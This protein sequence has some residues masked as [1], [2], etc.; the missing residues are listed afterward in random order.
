MTTFMPILKNNWAFRDPYEADH[1]YNNLRGL[2][3]DGNQFPH[4]YSGGTKFGYPGDPIK[5]VDLSDTEFVDGEYWSPGDRRSLM[6]AGPFNIAVGD[7][8]EIIVAYIVGMGNDALDSIIKLKEQI[9]L[10]QEIANNFFNI[11]V[12]PAI[13]FGL[14][15][16]NI[17]IV[18]DSY[19][20]D[21][22]A[23]NGETL[24][25]KI[26][27]TNTSYIEYNNITVKSKDNGQ[28]N[29][30]SENVLIPIIN[31]N[32][33][34]SLDEENSVII[35]AED[36]A[37]NEISHQLAFF[38]STFTIYQIIPFTLPIEQLYFTPL[39][40]DTL[41]QTFGYGNAILGFRYVE[42]NETRTDSYKVE[43]TSQVYDT[44]GDLHEGL[45][46]TLTKVTTGEILLDRF[47]LPD[48][49]GF[50]YPMTEGFKLLLLDKIMPGIK[51]VKVT[52][53]ASGILSPPVDCLPYWDR[54]E[55]IPPTINNSNQQATNDATW[56]IIHNMG[57]SYYL[58]KQVPNDF[59][60]RFTGNGK[61]IKYFHDQTVIDV[62][63]ECWNVGDS[64]DPT[65]DY[66]LIS[67]I[68]DQ[69][70][71]S[72]W[73][74]NYGFHSY[75]PEGEGQNDPTSEYFVMM[76]P[77]DK[78]PGTQGYDNFMQGA[79]NNP[80]L[81]TGD[82]R[83]TNLPWWGKVNSGLP[84][85]DMDASNLENI[86]LLLH[87]GGDVYAAT[88]PMD[89]IAQSPEIGTV[90][91]ITT[92]KPLT[93]GDTFKFSTQFIDIIEIND[94]NIPNEFKLYQNYPNPFNDETIIHFDIIDEID[95]DIKIFNILG[96]EIFQ[97]DVKQHPPGYHN[98]KWHG[99]NMNDIQMPTGIYFITMTAG[100]FRQ[101]G[102]LL[103]LK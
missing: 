52:S 7:S 35:K 71:N 98:I 47:R 74:L 48:E 82:W 85:D 24:K 56:L 54:S 96:Q 55:C 25:L 67:Y 43:I 95:L 22:I 99:Q 10:L 103:L 60:I 66:Q 29:Y 62:P 86:T 18:G 6:S 38:D 17:Q 41:N 90:F 91:K 83:D 39:D 31:A 40:V 13:D 3:F 9:P 88:S 64:D 11:I 87:N 78:T 97:Y 8:Q 79:E 42:A 63:F 49:Y 94:P 19:N 36:D 12:E 27:I 15:I 34:F 57:C 28:N 80:Y 44:I 46:V 37:S 75:R 26:D 51:A 68:W 14:E 65:D 92:N 1:A 93:V 72:E 21:H 23:N 69:D 73:N 59:E 100:D 16:T 70:E 89:Y 102:K 101:T 84:D 58:G 81:T 2:T 50:G 76:N 61:A 33:S 77:A 53:N 5:D 4:E 45:G 20:D 30:Y 32:S